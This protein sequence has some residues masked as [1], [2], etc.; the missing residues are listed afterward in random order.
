MSEK[1]SEVPIYKEQNT[2]QAQRWHIKMEQNWVL[3]VHWF[4]HKQA[5]CTIYT[6]I[7]MELFTFIWTRLAAMLNALL[8]A[9]KQQPPFLYKTLLSSIFLCFNFHLQSFY[10]HFLWEE[11]TIYLHLNS[12]VFLAKMVTHFQQGKFCEESLLPYYILQIRLWQSHL[13]QAFSTILL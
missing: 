8:K 6:S 3:R 1:E 4:K 9:T 7:I 2:K 12:K 11:A 10:C 5:I 13:T